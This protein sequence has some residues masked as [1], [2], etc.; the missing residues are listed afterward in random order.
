MACKGGNKDRSLQVLAHSHFNMRAFQ[1][2]CDIN[3][4]NSWLHLS[5]GMK[6]L[7]LRCLR[8]IPQGW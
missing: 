5:R 8:A 2:D 7:V 1:I 6:T 3:I 4:L